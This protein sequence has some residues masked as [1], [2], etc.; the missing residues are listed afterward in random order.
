MS[1]DRE[2]AVQQGSKCRGSC[3]ALYAFLPALVQRT[4]GSRWFKAFPVSC[5]GLRGEI[6]IRMRSRPRFFRTHL[7]IA[8]SIEP[9]FFSPSAHD[10]AL[11]IP[12]TVVCPL[13]LSEYWNVGRWRWCRGRVRIF[14]FD[15]RNVGLDVMV[16]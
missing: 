5:Y 15:Q 11:W 9:F 6:Y 3:A 4:K 1:T 14:F 16:F 12:E 8:E 13:C 10:N 2:T 7:S